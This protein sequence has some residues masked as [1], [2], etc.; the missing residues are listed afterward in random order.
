MSAWIFRALLVI[1]ALGLTMCSSI[2]VK[3]DHDAGADFSQFKTF[4]FAGLAERNRGTV[5]DN[6]LTRK[7]IES[8]VSRELTKKGLRRVE[9]GQPSDLL[10]HYWVTSKDKQ[11]V[12]GMG[13]PVGYYGV[14]GGYYGAGYSGV[15]TYNYREGTLI[16]DLIEPRKHQLVWRATMVAPL[17]RSAEDN[18]ELGNKAIAEAFEHYP[19]KNDG[20]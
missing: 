16:L 5:F 3:T 12:Q 4:A 18:V 20:S 8:A 11:N 7:R 2:D 6:S 13:P 19:P 15:T 1:G 10:V 9:E 14:R 17:E